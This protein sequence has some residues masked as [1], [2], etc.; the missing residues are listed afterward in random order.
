[1]KTIIIYSDELK[2]YDFGEGHPFRSNRFER[3]LELFKGKFSKDK[4]FEL[5][6][7]ITLATD[8]E[9]ELWHSKDYIK[10]MQDASQGKDVTNLFRFISGDNVNLSTKKLPQGIEKGA[11]AVVKNTLLAIDYNQQK[12][13]EKVVSIGGGLH[14]AMSDY[15]E[16]FCVYNDVVIAAKYAIEKYHL[17]RVLILDTDAHAGNGTCKAFYSNPKVL[18]V[19]THQKGIYPG[20]GSIDEIG[21]GKGK[22][23]TVNL[24]LEAGTGDK[25][26]ELIFDEIIFPLAREY[27]PQMIIRYGGSDPYFD[28]GL[29]SLGL[30]LD[31]FEMIGKK[32][33]ELSREL[34]ENRSVDLLCSGYNLEALPKI[35]L[36]LV[37]AISGVKID[38]KESALDIRDRKITETKNLIEKVKGK[39]APYWGSIKGE[40]REIY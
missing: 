18:F 23:F 7:N 10:T 29:T 31:G 1:M 40:T 19:D 13:T 4:R 30:T 39:L 26:Y 36:T 17:K 6:E 37:A 28:D 5:K 34:C 16:G 38:F 2:N 24:P 9:L 20:T 14:H 35:W 32:V 15:G 21:E 22:G 11:R 25:A 33:R 3:F 12:K 27:K 8:E